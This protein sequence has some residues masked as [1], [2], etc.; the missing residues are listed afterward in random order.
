MQDDDVIMKETLRPNAIS[1]GNKLARSV[2]N[3]VWLLLYRPTPIVL[4]G[5]RVFLLRMF[6]AK[7]GKKVE[8]YPSS[9]IWAP[10]NLEMDDYSGLGHHAEMYS[11]DKIVIKKRVNISQYAYLCT[12]THDYNDPSFP[13]LTAPIFIEDDVWVAADAFISL[14]V[15]I[16][17]GAIVGAR[18]AVFKDVA[19]WTI[20][21]GNPSAIIGQRAKRD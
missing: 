14:G 19:P 11:V 1:L 15:T 8:P 16:G 5:W 21:G 17:S 9:K 13:L 7:I 3:L 2:W 4:H 12:A 20:V 18:A 10:W 6:G